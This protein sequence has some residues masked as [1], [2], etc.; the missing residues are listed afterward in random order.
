MVTHVSP[1]RDPRT[2][3]TPD[4]FEVSQALLGL[5]L[6]SP[7]KRLAALLVDLAVIGVITLVTKSFALVL[8]IVAAVLFIREGFKRTE[9]RGSVFG[10][11]MRLSVGCLGLVV[12]MVTV[13]VWMAVGIGGGLGERDEPGAPLDVTVGGTGATG[14]LGTLLDLAQGLD[15]A[16]RLAEADDPQEAQSAATD[17]AVRARAAGMDPEQIRDVLVEAIPDQVDWADQTEEIV[18]MAIAVAL[19][20]TALARRAEERRVAEGATGS[21]TLG[22]VGD[23]EALRDPFVADTLMKLEARISSLAATA[24]ERQESL[25]EARDELR[26]EREGGSIFSWLRDFVDE[27]G[28]GFG[29]ASLYLTVMLSWWKGQ[30]VGKKMFGIRVVRLD[31]EPITWWTAF[32]RAGGYAAGFATGLLG[33]AQ[34]YW[35]SNRQAIHDRIVGTVVVV[36]GGKKVLDWE[37]AL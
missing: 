30:T 37:K 1:A 32:E 26:R 10:R 12:G 20:D 33:F 6:A 7:G 29:W 5:P 22:A 4:A 18:D 13:G 35:D 21:D 2:I 31:G 27:L 14:G 3:V 11:A 8:G 34:V 36:D 19:G 24:D 9:V 15:D 16:R 17:L 28:F 23:D 25:D